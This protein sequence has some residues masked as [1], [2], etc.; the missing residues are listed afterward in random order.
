MECEVPAAAELSASCDAIP[1][2]ENFNFLRWT[3]TTYAVMKT[4]GSAFPFDAA[5]YIYARDD[6]TYD[7]YARWSRYGDCMPTAKAHIVPAEDN[8]SQ[9]YLEVENVRRGLSIAK[10]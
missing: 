4:R 3:G 2:P 9:W 8:T 1:H 5:S 7:V 10:T 6:G